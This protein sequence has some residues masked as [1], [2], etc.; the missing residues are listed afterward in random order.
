MIYHACKSRVL[1]RGIP[2]DS[3]L[4]ELVEWGR[5]A[6]ESIFTV[7]DR[8]DIYTVIRPQLGPWTGLQHRRAAMMEALR[9]LAGFESSWRWN[10]GVDIT[11][12]HSLTHLEGQETGAFQVSFNSTSFDASLRDCVRRYCGSLKIH[13]FIERMKSDHRFAI[14]YAARLLRFTTRHNGPVL[15]REINPW[16]RKEA[17]AEFQVFL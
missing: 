12:H 8:E 15:R 16:L 5:S 10:E 4:D 9:V 14:E 3:F 1:T 7:N 6:D 13:T 11:N 17:V 2:P